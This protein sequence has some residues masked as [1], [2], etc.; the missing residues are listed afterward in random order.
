MKNPRKLFVAVCTKDDNGKVNSLAGHLS[1]DNESEAKYIT[2]G[3]VK[4]K[5]GKRKITSN[6][7][8]ENRS[9]DEDALNKV[10]SGRVEITPNSYLGDEERKQTIRSFLK[11][12]GKIK[13]QA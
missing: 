4:D 12:V 6:V 7:L 5:N 1:G 8:S 3:I 9:I 13:R 2:I 10:L 11:T